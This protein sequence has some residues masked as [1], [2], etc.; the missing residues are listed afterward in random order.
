MGNAD[1]LLMAILDCGSMDIS[2]LDDVGYEGRCH[3]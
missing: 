2:A 3:N 1:C